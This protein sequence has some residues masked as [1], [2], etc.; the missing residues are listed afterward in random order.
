MARELLFGLMGI[1][2]KAVGSW[3]LRMDMVHGK[4]EMA[5]SMK[6]SGVSICSMA[7]AHTLILPVRMKDSLKTS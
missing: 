5:V 1:F 7:K 4:P 6:D 3:A 2:F